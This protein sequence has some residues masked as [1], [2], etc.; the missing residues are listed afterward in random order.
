M[1]YAPEDDLYSCHCE[2]FKCHVLLHKCELKGM[3]TELFC[4]A[5][6]LLKCVYC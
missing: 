1:S 3:V 5:I 6:S 2:N 4:D